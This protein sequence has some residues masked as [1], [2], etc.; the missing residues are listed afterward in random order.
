MITAGDSSGV[1][2]TKG[3]KPPHKPLLNGDG[4]DSQF[5]YAPLMIGNVLLD[6]AFVYQGA[7][8]VRLV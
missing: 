1:Q 3:P 7:R 6:V 8:Q 4:Y 5:S 2:R